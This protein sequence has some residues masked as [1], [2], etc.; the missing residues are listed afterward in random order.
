M[1]RL[2]L[3][4]ASIVLC[5]SVGAQTGAAVS[6]MTVDKAQVFALSKTYDVTSDVMDET[7]KSYFLNKGN[8]LKKI[9]GNYVANSVSF[10][11][12]DNKRYD[13]YLNLDKAKASKTV[14]M[15]TVTI[16]SGF[17]QY[18]TDSDSKMKAAVEKL[19]IDLEPIANNNQTQALIA[20]KEK[21]L[22]DAQK[23]LADYQKIRDDAINNINNKQ[24]EIDGLIAELSNLKTNV[25]E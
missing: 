8:K 3:L 13:V 18:M 12:L 20:A 10:Q 11:N 4:I 23:K 25:N 6:V 1:K 9:K 17:N 24:T 22:R 5:I 21:Q 2:N 19:L 16:S 14:C 15:L 7:I